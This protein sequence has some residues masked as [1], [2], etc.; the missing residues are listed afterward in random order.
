MYK[1]YILLV[2]WKPSQTVGTYYIGDFFCKCDHKEVKAE[3]FVSCE[4]AYE[5]LNLF[6]IP[7]Y[8]RRTCSMNG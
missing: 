5:E 2:L 6:L 8:K 7:F 3:C 1:M 4:V